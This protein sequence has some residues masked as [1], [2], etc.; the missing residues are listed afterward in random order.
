MPIFNGVG[1]TQKEKEKE[2]DVKAQW[3]IIINSA[4][5]YDWAEQNNPIPFKKWPKSM[6]KALQTNSNTFVRTM[7]RQT[8]IASFPEMSGSH[9]G[10]DRPSQNVEYGIGG[11]YIF[12]KNVLPWRKGSNP[13]PMP[14]MAP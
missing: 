8:K 12:F 9:P 3:D 4:K 1:K 6:Y 2:K 5:I 13:N 11:K 7:V 14:T 10:K